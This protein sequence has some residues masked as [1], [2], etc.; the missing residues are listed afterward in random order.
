MFAGLKNKYIDAKFDLVKHSRGAKLL[1]KEY[2]I[3]KD[4][5]DDLEVTSVCK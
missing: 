4:C 1:M 5:D 2:K 3:Q